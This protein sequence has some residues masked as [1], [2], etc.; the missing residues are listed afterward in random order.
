MCRGIVVCFVY[1]VDEERREGS[2]IQD[3]RLIEKI[4]AGHQQALRLLIERYKGHVFKVTYSV[5]RDEKEAE[6]LA[7][8]TFIKM[9]D[10]LP[11]YQ[12]QGFKTWLSRIAM[13]KAI[14]YKRKKARQ[15]EDLA[16]ET[17]EYERMQSAEEEWLEREKV[18]AVSHSIGLLPAN[19]QG[20]VQAYYIEG[21]S[22]NEIAREHALEEK[23]VEMRLY[24][25]RK[26]MKRNWKEDEF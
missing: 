22:Y 9:M 5:V 6:D 26:W 11:S 20:V 2:R 14:D 23:T 16:Y 13:N 3:E 7:Q 21:K 17:L 1:K 4:K 24:R 10:A 15:K 12:S 19:Y 25:A 18:L 8:E